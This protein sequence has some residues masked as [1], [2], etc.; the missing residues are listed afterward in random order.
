MMQLVD[1]FGYAFVSAL[2]GA[3]LGVIGWWLHGLANPV[4]FS[5]PGIDP[6]LQHWVIYCS[7]GLWLLGFWQKERVAD[8]LGDTIHAI[9]HFEISHYPGRALGMFVCL[10]W[11][12]LL[13]AA[14]WA[15]AP[16]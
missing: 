8:L 9:Y 16:G 15:T 1:R 2:F 3:V 11:I 6:V 4:N 14:T 13:F 10:I 7:G 12:V 5:G